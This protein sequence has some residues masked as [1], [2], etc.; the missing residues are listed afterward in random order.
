MASI[1]PSAK[2]GARSSYGF[3]FDAVLPFVAAGAFMPISDFSG[4]QLHQLNAG[5]EAEAILKLAIVHFEYVYL[6]PSWRSGLTPDT[7]E[8]SDSKNGYYVGATPDLAS[9]FSTILIPALS[10]RKK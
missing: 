10:A 4:R 5:G 6:R 9:L 2:C 7:R 3:S 8:Y 1:T